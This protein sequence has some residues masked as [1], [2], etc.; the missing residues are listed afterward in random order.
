MK[1][2]NKMERWIQVITGTIPHTN[3]TVNID[4]EGRNLI[5][6]GANGSGKTS[7]LNAVNSKLDT[8]IVEKLA[9]SLVQ[10]K[11][12]LLQWQQS[13][14]QSE[15]GTA[16]YSQAEQNIY[17]FPL[18]SKIGINVTIRTPAESMELSVILEA[19]MD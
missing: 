15:K 8:L 12:N 17:Y 2:K 10:N 19:E 5:V 1:E 3:K 16:Q 14:S 13:L 18:V 6:T 4:L 7:F 9:S 11:Q